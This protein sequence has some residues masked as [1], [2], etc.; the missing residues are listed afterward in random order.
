MSAATT[1][2]RRL[3]VRLAQH[4]AWVLPSARTPWSDAMRRE[5]DYITDDPV[6]VRWALGC[7]LASY[8]ARLTDQSWLGVRVAWRPAA[9][10]GALMLLIGLALLET[11]GGQTAPPQ[12][13]VDTTSCDLPRVSPA[14]DRRPTCAEPIGRCEAGTAT[15]LIDQAA[16]GSDQL[17]ADRIAPELPHAPSSR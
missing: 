9:A 12:A 16:R 5:L 7:M 4:A 13:P 1:C 3:A 8:R 14:I 6:A 15:A 11:A 17:C 2:W 10:S